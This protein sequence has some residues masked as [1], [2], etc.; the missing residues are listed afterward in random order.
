MLWGACVFDRQVVLLVF[1]KI[2]IDE[3]FNP[4]GWASVPMAQSEGLM[5]ILLHLFP[6]VPSIIPP[7]AL[8]RD[9]TIAFYH[10]SAVQPAIRNTN[11]FISI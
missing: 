11:C 1:F 6:S 3:Q 9:M 4:Q 5:K 10:I 7:I 8:Y 2:F